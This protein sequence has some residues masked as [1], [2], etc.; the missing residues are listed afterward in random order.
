MV[1]TAGNDLGA[2]SPGRAG[3]STAG[4]ALYMDDAELGSHYERA[5][6]SGVP[7]YLELATKEYG[8]RSYSLRDPEGCEWTVGSYRAGAPANA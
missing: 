6:A 3:G 2:V 8:G 4:I 1:S 5:K 7:I